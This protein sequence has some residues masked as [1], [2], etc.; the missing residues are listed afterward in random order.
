VVAALALV[1]PACGSDPAAAPHSTPDGG[2]GPPA[3][4]DAGTD[5]AA[6]GD[7]GPS[8][9]SRTAAVEATIANDPL[10][11]AIPAFYWEIGDVSGP[12][13][14]GAVG[15]TFSATT[16]MGIAS[17]SKLVFG[18]Y[19]VERFK[20]D[21]T[22]IDASAMRMLSGYTSFANDS[23]VG[24][25]TVADCFNTGSNATLTPANV[26]HFYYNGG[27]FQKYAV[28]L[29]LGGDDDAALTA[30]IKSLIGTELAFAYGSPQLAGGIRTTASDYAVFLRK[31]LSGG[32]AI[33]AHL[34][35]NAVC[36][37]PSAC[38][39]A[40][41]SPSP[42]A[43][44]YSYGHWVEDDPAAGDG[45]FSS[46]GLFGF[47]PWIDAGKKYYG[48]LARYS[49]AAQAYVQSAECGARVRKA[50]LT[51]SQP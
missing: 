12:L 5:A 34:G 1:A 33:G 10:C 4:G 19:V 25:S 2:G 48:I 40:R 46:P 42:A 6:G 37:L 17:A 24:T 31:I 18:A 20:S 45:A 38:P 41:Y 27:H 14:S 15:T 32:L 49:L 8:L 9:A 29:G 28:D 22:R 50:F 23:C 35:E 3:S 16:T 51:G 43:W 11:T 36:T 21:L 47:Y 13:A 39:T 30:D 26:D 44:H 7:A